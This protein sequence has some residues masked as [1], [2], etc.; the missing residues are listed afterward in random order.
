MAIQQRD[1]NNDHAYGVLI[2]S[3]QNSLYRVISVIQS[4]KCTHPVQYFGNALASFL[5]T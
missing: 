3:D 5:L 4:Q 2:P 1:K